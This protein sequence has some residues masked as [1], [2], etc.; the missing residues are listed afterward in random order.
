MMYQASFEDGGSRLNWWADL[1]RGTPAFPAEA[2]VGDHQAEPPRGLDF[3]LEVGSFRAFNIENGT[4]QRGRRTN[5][6]ARPREAPGQRRQVAPERHANVG[7][8]F[9]SSC[10]IRRAGREFQK[11]QPIGAGRRLVHA[12]GHARAPVRRLR[13]MRIPVDEDGKADTS[14]VR[15]RRVLL[16][17]AATPSSPAA[18][19]P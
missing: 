7:P 9:Q 1:R 15:D 3:T 11:L 6:I 14:L 16:D 13:F 8:S 19:P 4:G 17:K 5:T 10:G 2:A 12:V 18:S